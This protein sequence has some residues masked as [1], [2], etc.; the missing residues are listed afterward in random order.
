MCALPVAKYLKIAKSYGQSICSGCT[1]LLIT[2]YCR[3]M[4]GDTLSSRALNDSAS[5]NYAE[6]FR[7]D[8]CTV[9]WSL[10]FCEEGCC[11]QHVLYVVQSTHI[12][13]L[14]L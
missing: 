7:Y 12:Q 4:V 13:T 6:N 5:I 1:A 3:A 14:L 8:A 2:V 9:A 10:R 11:K